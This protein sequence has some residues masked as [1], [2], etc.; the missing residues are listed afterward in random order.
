MQTMQTEYGQRHWPRQTMQT[1]HWPRQSKPTKKPVQIARN[2]TG[3]NMT[4]KTRRAKTLDECVTKIEAYALGFEDGYNNALDDVKVF[5]VLW[6][7]RK[8]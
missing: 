4:K 6:G 3:E 1:R 8:K 7:K 5:K 2:A